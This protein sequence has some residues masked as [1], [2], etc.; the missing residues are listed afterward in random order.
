MSRKINEMKTCNKLNNKCM[1][2]NKK[3]YIID[4]IFNGCSVYG[5]NLDSFNKKDVEE[6]SVNI[7]KALCITLLD[8]EVI[9]IIKRYKV[10]IFDYEFMDENNLINYIP[11]NVEYIIFDSDVLFNKPIYNYPLSLK[12]IRFGYYYDQPIDYL[13]ETV[14]YLIF[15]YSFNKSISNIPI[16]VQYISFNNLFNHPI[17]TL[18]DNIKVL[19]LNCNK[20]KHDIIKFPKNIEKI[21][22]NLGLC[23]FDCKILNSIENLKKIKELEFEYGFNYSIDNIKWPDTIKILK[24]S[25]EFNQPINN[26]PKFLESI[27]VCAPFDLFK[28]ITSL[29]SKL[30][31]FIYIDTFPKCVEKVNR[32]KEL[33]VLFPNIK[34]INN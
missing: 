7:D 33:E 8:I 23:V 20:F 14:K 18:S 21:K 26:L 22:L 11:N 31:E 19:Y 27:T 5:F 30:K 15:G 29:P 4:F 1:E 13:P 34:F 24:F 17:D 9:E 25:N 12:Y 16:S 2:I 10:I 6:F 28:N 3:K 32:L